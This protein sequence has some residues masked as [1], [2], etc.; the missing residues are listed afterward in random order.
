MAA[1]YVQ[2]KKIFFFCLI[3]SLALS[4][5]SLCLQFSF[6]S[7]INQGLCT[8]TCL[9]FLLLDFFFCGKDIQISGHFQVWPGFYFPFKSLASFLCC[10]Q[11]PSVE[12]ALMDVWWVRPALVSFLSICS[13]PSP[14]N[15]LRVHYSSY[16]CLIS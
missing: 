5:S 15:A 10:A 2:F 1:V 6:Q 7:R 16:D 8:N 4:G 3:L 14:W 11:A 13:L 12:D 9:A